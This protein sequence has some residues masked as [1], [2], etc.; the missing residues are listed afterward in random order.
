MIEPAGTNA[1]AITGWIDGATLRSVLSIL[2]TP[3]LNP[4]VAD[5]MQDSTYLGTIDDRAY[6]DDWCCNGRADEYLPATIYSV[7]LTDGSEGKHVDLAPDPQAHPAASQPL[8]Q[9]E[10]NYMIGSYLYV[11]VGSVTYR[12]DV[13][14][15]NRGPTRLSTPPSSGLSDN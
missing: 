12:Y 8:G 15:L 7:S 4:V 13:R 3:T 11:V 2:R 1:V 5:D 6:I 9:G 14:D 10:H